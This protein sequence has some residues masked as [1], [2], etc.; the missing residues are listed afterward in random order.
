MG[1]CKQNLLS[2]NDMN[3]VQCLAATSFDFTEPLNQ[4]LKHRQQR[5]VN[6]MRNNTEEFLSDN[7]SRSEPVLLQI[8][9]KD[10]LDD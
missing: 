6:K 7:R 2:A 10:W 3:R 4:A 9:M 5:E 1:N 8:N